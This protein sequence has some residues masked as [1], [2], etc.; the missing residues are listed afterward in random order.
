M[1]A[2]FWATLGHSGLVSLV[3]SCR[4]TLH[5]CSEVHFWDWVRSPF[6]FFNENIFAWDWRCGCLLQPWNT[7]FSCHLSFLQS[8][9]NLFSLGTISFNNREGKTFY[10]KL[11]IKSEQTRTKQHSSF[12]TR[13]LVNSELNTGFYSPLWNVIKMLPLLNFIMK[14]ILVWNIVCF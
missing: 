3:F 13:W 2:Q 7:N 14:I 8:A 1:D 12:Q 10:I 11:N 9:F 4:A 6:I 5:I